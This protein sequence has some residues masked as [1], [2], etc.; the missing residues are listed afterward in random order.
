MIKSNN[1]PTQYKIKWD[2]GSMQHLADKYSAT[3]IRV[4]GAARHTEG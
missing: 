1:A 2:F 3:I 4:Y